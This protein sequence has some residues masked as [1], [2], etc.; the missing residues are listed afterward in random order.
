MRQE[1]EDRFADFV[2]ARSARLFRTAYLMTGDYQRAED[3]LQTTL[4]R[5][6]QRWPQ[7]DA[8][9]RPGA[10]AR[11]VLVSQAVS[12]WR[13]RSSHETGLR[14]QHEPSWDGRVDEVAENHR[15]WQAVL[16]LPP[17]QRA[18]IVL[19]YYEDLSEAE[20]AETLHMA[21]G[22]VKSHRLAGAR[23]LAVLLEE[24]TRHPPSHVAEAAS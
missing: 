15:V 10:Y 1:E 21:R 11:K 12:W 18:V 13:R 19:Q 6:Y 22:T 5:L 3:L 17:R 4:L 20:I 24:P 23:R 9:E 8:M 14:Q 7:V 2:R 16:T